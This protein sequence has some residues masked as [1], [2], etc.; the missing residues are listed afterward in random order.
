M[1]PSSQPEHAVDIHIDQS[2]GGG[3]K[4]TLS[5]RLDAETAGAWWQELEQRLRPL[6]TAAIE[7]D[8]ARLVL[9][10]SIGIAL[11]RYL[12]DGAITPGAAVTVIGLSPRFRKIMNVFTTDDFRAHQAHRPHPPSVPEEVGAATHAVLKDLGEQVAFVGAVLRIL[13]GVLVH[14][15]RMRWGEVKRVVETAG[16][17]AL[18]VVSL[19]SWLIGLVLALEAARPLEKLGAQVFIADLVGFASVR[20][21]GPLV[22]AIMLAGRSGSAI[23]AELGTMKVNDELDA[24]RTMG[25]EPTQFLVVQRVVGAVLLTPLLA[26]YAMGMSILGGV[27]VLRFLGFPPR[28]IFHQMLGRVQLADLGIGLAKSVIFGLIVACVGCLRG[29]QTKEGA[30]AVGESTTRSVV[31]CI[32]LIVVANTL[33]STVNYFLSSPR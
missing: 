14:P 32:V 8:A 27:T 26:L 19:F 12:T 9:K 1:Q 16:A 10:G 7:V 3:V 15:K 6:G 18:P 22:T 13:P 25:L 31:A 30:R 23:A 11:L 24:L 4:V 2:S 5:G 17:N 28:L 29:I 33:F 21:T 20:S